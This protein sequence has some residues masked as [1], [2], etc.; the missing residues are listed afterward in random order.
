MR[1][2]S[3]SKKT[4]FV[5]TVPPACWAPRP[6]AAGSATADLRTGV[7]PRDD[8]RRARGVEHTACRRVGVVEGD[9]VQ[10]IRQPQIVIEAEAEE[11]LGLQE[12]C[13]RGVRL[14][15]ARNRTDE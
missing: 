3:T 10:Q 12:V 7:R 11:L 14:E 9:G 1:V 2:K 8:Q 4:A 6:I 15:R 5:D 13:N